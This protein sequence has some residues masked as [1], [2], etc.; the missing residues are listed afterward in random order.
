MLYS[1]LLSAPV[2]FSLVTP[3]LDQ[4]RTIEQTI[5]SVL[6]QDYPGFEHIVLDG[7]ST[8]ETIGILKR[9]PHLRWISGP[10]AGQTAAINRGLAMSTGAIFAYLNADDYF[11]PGALPAVAEVFRQD[12]TTAV[13][14]GD[15]LAVDAESRLV[16]RYRAR[17]DRFEDML[18]YWQWGHRFCIPQSSVFVR[19]GLFDR[20][21]RFDESYDL[22]MDYEMWLRL[23][24][25]HPFTIL[26]RTLA[27]FR[28]G[29]ETKTT[30]RR[31]EMDLEQFRAS[32]RFWRLARLPDR[33]T[34][35]CEAL[36]RAARDLY[37]SWT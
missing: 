6:D 34:I 37:R 3:S 21:G 15:G 29:G 36:A 12:P 16:A 13:V 1:A 35:P 7:G 31:A 25:R 20:V 19:R 18:R 14:V 30:R 8:D 9:Y 11:C 10:D 23:A 2:S 27:A 26:P 22:A 32:R 4:G 5:R 28:V 33:W 24:A 17:L